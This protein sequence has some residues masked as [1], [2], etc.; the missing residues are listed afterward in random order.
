MD[1]SRAGASNDTL[2]SIRSALEATLDPRVSNNIRVQALNHL[3]S[4]KAQPFAPQYGFA[5]AND[6]HQPEPVRYYGL[7]LLEY[8]VRY[9]WL[10]YSSGHTEQIRAWIQQLAANLRERDPLFIRNKVAQLWTEVAKRCWGDEWMDMDALLVRLWNAEMTADRGLANKLFVL[11]VLEMLNEDIAGSKEDSI[12]GL[13][14]VVLGHALNEITIP[15]GLY[16]EHME[17]RGSSVEVREHG[18]GWL[19]RTSTFFADCVKQARASGGSDFTS[20]MSHCAVKALNALKPMVSWVSPK[21]VHEVGCVDCFFLPFHTSDAVL[22]TAAT[23]AL[24]ALLARQFNAHFNDIWLDIVNQALRPD[25]ISMIKHAFQQSVSDPGEDDEKHTLQEK[26]SEV[27]S[28]LTTYIAQQQ[29]LVHQDGNDLPG[30]FELL[31]YALQSS[32][33]LVSIPVLHA[34]TKLLASQDG[35]V[36]DLVFRALGALLETCSSRLTRFEALPEESNHHVIHWLYEDF[37]TMPER[38][39]FLGNYRRYCVSIIESIARS[40][41][42]EALEH[43]LAQTQSLLSSGPYARDRGFDASK[44]SKTSPSV[45]EFDAQFNVVISTLKGFSRWC[46]DI[47]AIPTED[48]LHDKAQQD[49]AAAVNMIQQWSTGV[50]NV[51]IDDPEAASQVLQILVTILRTV[52]QQ[53]SIEFVLQ[54]VQHILSMSLD[55]D[56]QQ[57]A[58]SETVKAFEALRVIEL[59]KIA[60]GFPNDL[61]EVYQE[62]EPRIATLAGKHAEDSRLVWGYRSFLFMIVHR[63]QRISQ[64]VKVERLRSM[65][66][67]VYEAWQNQG[68]SQSMS[69][70]QAFCDSMSL[71]GLPDFWQHYSFSTVADWSSQELDRP[72]QE[73][74]TQI[75]NRSQD[76]LPLRMTKS[77]L[78]AT[79]EKLREDS[80]DF[81]I[82]ATIWGPA[83]PL[84]LPNLLPMLKHAQAFHNPNNWAQLPDEIQLVVKRTLQDRFWQSGI[85]SESKDEFYAR[86]AGS[87]TSFEGFASTV[88]GAMRNVR[89]QGYHLIYLMTKFEE[90]FYGLGEELSGGLSSALFDD[91]RY[92]SANHLHPVINLVTGLVQRCP[93]HHRTVFLPQILKQLFTVMDAKIVGEWETIAAVAA[94]D[95]GAR[96]NDELSDEM[97]TESVLRQLTYS[98]VS[99]V[100][101]LLDYDKM[102]QQAALIGAEGTPSNGHNGAH[103]SRPSLSDMVLS[104]PNILEPLILFCTHAL[105]VRDTRCCTTI[106]RVFRNMIPKFAGDS[107]PAPQV[108]EFICTEVLKACITSLNE[109]YF[110]DMQRDLAALIAQILLLYAPKTDTP[111]DVLR[112]LSG[113]DYTKVDKAVG[114][115]VRSSNERTQRAV[116]LELLEG[117]RGVSIYESGKVDKG[118]VGA[119]NGQKKERSTVKQQ[120]MEV[121]QRPAVVDG[122]EVGLEELGGLFGDA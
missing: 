103:P 22:Q 108:R 81:D 77:L 100:T 118:K 68:L 99:F 32:S 120:Y 67:P 60:L 87:K 101:F 15:E 121:E 3:E 122:S 86:I 113:M 76:D 12:A 39:A 75:Q 34:W 4:V 96:D 27:L 88:R 115:I 20:T 69:S 6:L 92:L 14:C 33:L 57:R 11:Y 48:P 5:L 106:T 70:F 44:W 73:R 13:R 79:A 10:D 40:R 55:D 52:K 24:Y 26:L 49:K 62:L 56:Q 51:H 53:Y 23:E 85:S 41:P 7:Q 28:M 45:L 78:A 89:E 117:V 104:N 61:L 30:F 58:Y 47:N 17:T 2:N 65:L 43:V 80:E 95:D 8:A 105:R 38:H 66:T 114:K 1:P 21:A 59:Q 119:S 46:V 84:I 16:R 91:A 29:Q 71:S 54:V 72:G 110:A 31:V 112:S 74:Q 50:L 111:R 37:D 98:M 90:S 42:L 82:A 9:R 35:T 93:P 83:I 19:A 116:V 97:R 64:E 102:Q 25:R 107:A 63:A 94:R 36:I 18:P 109:P